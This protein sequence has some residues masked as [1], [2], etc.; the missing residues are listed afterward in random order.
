M[1]RQHE[2]CL[3]CVAVSTDHGQA[4]AG[5]LD[6]QPGRE[7]DVSTRPED[8]RKTAGESRV[9]ALRGQGEPLVNRDIQGEPLVIREIQRYAVVDMCLSGCSRRGWSRRMHESFDSYVHQWVTPC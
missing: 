6:A 3:S 5:V 2:H 4:D 7:V 9:E 1:Q 8:G